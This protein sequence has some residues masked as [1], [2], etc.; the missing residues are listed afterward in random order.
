MRHMSAAAR[1]LRHLLRGL[2]VLLAC[3]AAGA[4]VSAAAQQSEAIVCPCIADTVVG[5]TPNERDRNFGALR[6]L[7][8]GGRDRFLLLNFDLGKL[9]GMEVQ[10]ATLR[11]HRERELL[12]RVGLSTIATAWPEG[13]AEKPAALNG[14]CCFAW[15]AWDELVDSRRPWSYPGGTFADV[16]FGRGGSR[17]VAGVAKFD[18][19]SMW[20]EI[21]VPPALVQALVQ[22]HQLGGLCVA[23]DFGRGE[24]RPVVSARESRHAPELVVEAERI[25]ESPSAPATNL[26]AERDRLGLEFL[27]FEAPRALGFQVALSAAPVNDAAAWS[28]ARPLPLWALPA[29]GDGRLRAMLSL[30]REP[31]HRFAAVRTRGSGGA[32]SP[33]VSVELL[34]PIG[35]SPSFT[36]PRLARHTLPDPI[37]APF[38]MD[39]GPAV[40]SDGRWIRSDRQTW[41]DPFKGPITL[42]AGRNEFVAFQ[43]ILAGG[44]GTYRVRFT[45]WEA[46]GAAAPAPT[47]ELFRE[48][49]VKARLGHEKYAPD[50]AVPLP[51]DADL[52][53][54]LL[55]PA[56]SQPASSQPQRRDLVQG[57]WVD[58]YVPHQCAVGVW[59]RR[60][61]VLHDGVAKLDIPLELTVVPAALPDELHFTVALG[62]GEPPVLAAGLGDDDP[63]AWELLNAYHRLTHRHRATLAV[64]P[65]RSDGRVWAGFAPEAQV[66]GADVRCDWSAWDQRFGRFL[67]GAAFRDLPRAGVPLALFPLPLSESWPAPPRLPFAPAD[68]PLASKYHFAPTTTERPQGGTPRN[69][70]R[71]KYLRWPIEAAVPADYLAQ[72]TAAARELAAHVQSSGW[73]RTRFLVQPMSRVLAAARST[74]WQFN[75]PEVPDDFHAL[76][77]WLAAWRAGI[78]PQPGPLALAVSTGTV[79]FERGILGALPDVAVVDRA[80]FDEHD[81]L[82]GGGRFGELWTTLSDFEPELGW[83]SAVRWGWA[84]RIA[85]GRGI[86]SVRSLGRAKAWSEA[87]TGALVYPPAAGD[88]PAGG[89]VG[90]AVL[91]TEPVASLRLKALR[92]VQQDMEWLELWRARRASTAPE[93]YAL[94]VV[95]A[96]LVAHARPRLPRHVALLP[97][98]N[99]DGSADTLSFEELRRGLRAALQE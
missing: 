4:A 37:T 25:A 9:A 65:Y 62:A 43:I 50:V 16:V 15:Q 40:S 92:R 23:D 90:P 59:K 47:V 51:L 96:E 76:R 97:L 83:S 81:A 57:L 58:L 87:D 77:L 3:T 41:W 88:A 64:V 56:A 54:Q 53:L 20:Y 27:T 91:A 67:D 71:D 98:L 30:Q 61:I 17:W 11:L 38:T 33:P 14:A 45:D 5:S 89:G 21:D 66:S 22:Q 7:E 55:S 79:Q 36:A 26:A 31:E 80:L 68:A 52:Q 85:G 86:V 12:T 13:T 60:V 32:W 44:P 49:Y 2:A 34:P 29:P 48:H 75:H 94:S 1:P 78:G 8:F 93:G 42:E 63:A 28:R 72:Q 84:T 82:V 39:D 73:T 69:P 70:P 24:V 19:E 95:G 6:E 99:F 74:W 18:K 35:E 10:R 46:P